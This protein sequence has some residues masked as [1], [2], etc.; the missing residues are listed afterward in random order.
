VSQVAERAAVAAL[1]DNSGWADRIRTETL[2]NRERLA[3]E[4]RSRGL[5]PLPSQA[6]F[7]LIPVDPA[8]AVDVNRAL[9]AH[10]VAGRPF[11]NLPDV[12]DALRITIGP[13]DLMERFLGALDQLFQPGSG[14]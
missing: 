12:G 9:Q 1:E 14:G 13:W 4:L 8:S 3:K 6:N 7:L 10:G 11:T 2:E 5:H